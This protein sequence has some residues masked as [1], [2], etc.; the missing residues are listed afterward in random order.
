MKKKA[1]GRS[2]LLL[3][4][5]ILSILFFALASAVCLQ[6]FV[7]ASLIGKDTKELD[8]AVR[9]VTSA[10]E[11]L[12]QAEEPMKQIM[13]QYPNSFVLSGENSITLLFDEDIYSCDSEHM[14]YQMDI[15]TVQSDIQTTEWSV[16]LYKDHHT[17]PVYQLEGTTYRQYVPVEHL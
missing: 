9:C 7:K 17:E 2:S 11:L 13:E 1:S 16:I 15:I 14:A 10:A 6:I 5:L 4:E 3:M 8:Q 12:G